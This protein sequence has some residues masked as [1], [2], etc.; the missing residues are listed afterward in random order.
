MDDDLLN[1]SVTDTNEQG[2]DV[3]L[4]FQS[5]SH[6]FESDAIPVTFTER[7]VLSKPHTNGKHIFYRIRF[8]EYAAQINY[9]HYLQLVRT[10][11]AT[12]SYSFCCDL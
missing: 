2:K 7:K 3:K 9:T 10:M 4:S 5:K 12:Y 1:T 6:F 11:V 8:L